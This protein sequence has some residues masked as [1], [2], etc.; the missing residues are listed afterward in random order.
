[1]SE[2][3]LNV[4]GLRKTF[5]LGLFKPDKEVLRGVSFEVRRG[6]IFGFLGPNGAGK[7]TTIKAITELIYPDE[8]E[9]TITGLPHTSLDA[10]AKIGFM[11]ENA[12]FYNHL[13]GVEFLNLCADLLHL[14]SDVRESRIS[15]LLDVVGLAGRG[16]DK[17]QT[18]S[19]GMLQR[20]G[21]AQALL[22]KPELL[23]LDEPMSGLDPIGRRDVRDIILEQRD[24]GTTIFFS[25]HIIPDVEM[26]CDR[27]AILIG[28]VVKSVGAVKEIVAREVETYELTFSGVDPANLKTEVL[29]SLRGGESSWAKV[30]SRHRDALIEEL[31]ATGGKLIS[32][33]P[34]RSRLEDFLV[35][36]YD[37]VRR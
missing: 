10:K 36:Q 30:E 8:G 13:T 33:T 32:L 26:I 23:I 7:T 14:D 35:A 12:Y 2:T 27:V 1:L 20:I 17:M 34:V 18:Y 6:E 37:E 19:K 29:A 16:G 11:P 25:S 15:E 22:G 9:I 3:V 5:D 28:G 21:L 24:A 4:R 31:R